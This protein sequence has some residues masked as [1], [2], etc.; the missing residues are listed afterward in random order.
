MTTV[1]IPFGIL[2]I[3]QVFYLWDDC[4]LY[5]I[6]RENPEVLYPMRLERLIIFTPQEQALNP[7]DYSLTNIIPNPTC[8][9]DEAIGMAY[10]A[11]Q[12]HG[13]ETRLDII[14]VRIRC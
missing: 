1:V 4:I 12:L 5:I 10:K 3:C 6:I 7:R 13:L 8:A 2:L 14:R 9:C 11:A